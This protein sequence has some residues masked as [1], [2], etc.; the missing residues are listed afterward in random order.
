MSR[1]HLINAKLKAGVWRAVVLSEVKLDH[2][3]S[4]AVMYDGNIQ[5][6]VVLEVAPDGGGQQWL[7]TFAV[8]AECLSDGTQ[9]FIVSDTVRDE[10]V[11]Q[12]TIQCGPAIEAELA[13]DVEL[14]RAELDLLKRAF[15][16]HCTNTAG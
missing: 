12:F 2:P 4:L 13:A 8:P 5:S 14:L 1:L 9:L 10:A 3:P 11:G 15:R 7:L 6:G 16:R